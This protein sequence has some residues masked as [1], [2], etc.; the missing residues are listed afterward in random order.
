MNR[1]WK[2]IVEPLLDYCSVNSIVEIGVAGGLNTKNLINYC[3][4]KGC[5][6]IGID[7]APLIDISELQHQHSFMTFYKDISLNAL[8]Q[9]DEFDVILIDGDHN[10][11]TVFNELK[12][13]ET[14]TLKKNQFPLI[15]LHDI[16]WPYGRRDMYY[17]PEL[18]PQ[19][20]RKPYAKLGIK[21]GKSKL[22]KSNNS[23]DVKNSHLNNALFEGGKQNGVMT[24]IEDFL[25][26][27][28]MPVGFESTELFHGL[29][30]LFPTNNEYKLQK[31]IKQKLRFAEKE[32]F[33]NK[34]R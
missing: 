33:K 11:Y 19:E 13:I 14:K 9:I 16:S 15:F 5:N 3:S 23:R 12:I 17:N 4:Q 21:E 8:S 25:K 18:I 1:Y 31:V 6:Y 26:S 27:T 30:V 7:P 10:W 20:F 34:K 22:I 2:D 24:A 28:K 32:Y 29:G